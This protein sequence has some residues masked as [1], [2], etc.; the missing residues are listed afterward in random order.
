[1]NLCVKLSPIFKNDESNKKTMDG[2]MFIKC[3]IKVAHGL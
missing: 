1:M 2:W 3:C